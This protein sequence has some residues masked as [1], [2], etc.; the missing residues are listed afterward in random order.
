MSVASKSGF[1]LDKEAWARFFIAIGGLALAFALAVFST[2]LRTA[3]QIWL[4]SVVASAALLLAGIVGLTTVPYLARRVALHRVRDAF[5]YEVTREG[6][7]YMLMVLV[8]GVAALNTG[9]NLLFIVVSAMLAAILVSG[10]ASA[11]VLRSLQLDASL[12]EHIFA[13]SPVL[14]RMVVQNRRRFLPSF[15]VTLVP[16]RIKKRGKRLRWEPSTFAFPTKAPR[17][18][19]WLRLPD[20]SLQLVEDAET[21]SGIFN[22]R[23][24]FPYL[25]ARGSVTREVELHFARR[26]RY[27]QDGFGLSTR[28]P[29]SF[30]M[31][32]RRVP[33]RREI[34]VYPSVSETDELFEI[35][36]M[37]TGEF[38]VFVRGRGHDLYGLREY[39]PHD[40][41]RHVDWK[42]TARTGSLKVRE[43]TREDERKLRI[44][45]DNPR[46][47]EVAA[48]AYDRAVDLAASL[49]WHFAGENTDLSFLAPGNEGT[50]DI[51]SFLRYLALAE[52]SQQ[53][54]SELDR[55]RVSDDYNVIFTARPRGS[56]PTSLWACSYFI[57]MNER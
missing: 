56:I 23:L 53:G 19:Q 5:D 10:V 14:A 32:T 46:A 12:P 44:V 51:Y 37:I 20:V 55:L 38:E 25:P 27:Q 17:H 24:Y 30:L 26:G 57:F 29:F 35:L 1:H 3:G 6:V 52:P 54:E 34:V 33:L 47:G 21:V 7:V 41:A 18:R 9:N 43:Y 36:P 49:A 31:K 15:S 40:L 11:S 2:V 45:F 28:F 42:A 50:Q 48:E 13:G 16:P 39:Q 22:D 8:I 4:M